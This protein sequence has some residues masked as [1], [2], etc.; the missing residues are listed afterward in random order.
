M[1]RNASLRFLRDGGC[2]VSSQVLPVGYPE[3]VLP[4]IRKFCSAPIERLTNSKVDGEFPDQ[5]ASDLPHDISDCDSDPSHGDGTIHA[6]TKEFRKQEPKE[7]HETEANGSAPWASRKGR[8]HDKKLPGRDFQPYLFQIVLD[9]PRNVLR[10]VLDKWIEDGNRLERNEVLLV[11]FHLRKQ[12]LYQKALQFMEWIERGKLLNFEERDYACHLDL[13]ARNRGI[14]AAQKYIERIPKPFRNEVLY[15]TLLVNCVCLTNVQ[16]AEEVFKEIRDLSLP[17]TISAC[18]QMILL[19]KRVA[20][21]KVVDILM[22]MEKENIQLS[23]FTYK[24]LVDLKGRSNDTLGME[25]VLNM[26]KD[27]GVEPDFTTQTMVA[28]FYI[29]GGLLEKAEEVIRAMEVYIKDKRHAIRSLLDLYAVLGRPDDVARIWKSCTEPNLED[30]LAAIEAWG[31][32]G[33]IEQV[34]E[35]F[36]ALLKTSPKLT[37]KYYNAMLNVYAENKLLAKGK[38]FLERMFLAGCSNGPLTWDALVKLYVNSGEV[39]KADS[40]LLNVTEENPDRRPLFRSFI[41]LL[42]AY[43]E[44][45]DI[46]NAEKIFDRLKQI[47]HP[48]RTPPYGFLLEAYVNAGVPAHG[49]RERIRADNVRPSKTVIERLKLLDNLQ[50]Q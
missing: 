6:M 46:H 2:Q 10:D 14:E 7:L 11:L 38:E 41:I 45:G 30:Y 20:R 3:N 24:L 39:E 17:L 8:F 5:D 48:G 42:K 9:T 50:K 47:R 12:R 43:A 33:C 31:K 29:S 34:E 28:K 36:E 25:S 49:F 19:Y 40:F 1:L 13:I 16:K 27:N 35:T 44:K 21:S 23:P 4:L 15:E 32:L 22:L 37:S 26:M 18:N